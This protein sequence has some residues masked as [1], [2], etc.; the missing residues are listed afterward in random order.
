MAHQLLT[1]SGDLNPTETIDKQKFTVPNPDTPITQIVNASTE[2]RTRLQSNIGNY[3]FDINDVLDDLS[4]IKTQFHNNLDDN[5][6][7]LIESYKDNAEQ[8]KKEIYAELQRLVSKDESITTQG[9]LTA[10][11]NDAKNNPTFSTAIANHLECCILKRAKYLANSVQQT[12]EDTLTQLINNIASEQTKHENKALEQSLFNQI[13][14]HNGPSSPFDQKIY[15]KLENKALAN[16]QLIADSD[17]LTD[18]LNACMSDPDKTQILLDLYKEAVEEAAKEI[19]D[20][21]DSFISTTVSAAEIQT[22]KDDYRDF[23]EIHTDSI[24]QQNAWITNLDLACLAEQEKKTIVVLTANKN[25]NPMQGV[26]DN[27]IPFE[28]VDL[29]IFYPSTDH[30]QI[31]RSDCLFV[32]YNGRDHYRSVAR[33]DHLDFFMEQIRNK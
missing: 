26:S 20:K 21:T 15:E 17:T 12:I 33:G 18:A 1:L 30:T 19:K 3:L 7:N 2:L 9:Y 10:A 16:T 13:L 29:N 27:N 22:L 4:A 31:K 28:L 11:L 8:H 24:K 25:F 32:W 6:I 23:K 5:S 14:A